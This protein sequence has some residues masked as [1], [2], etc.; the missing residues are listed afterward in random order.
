MTCKS[1]RTPKLWSIAHENGRNTRKRQVVG[2]GSKKGID[3][4]LYHTTTLKLRTI[5][6]KMAITHENDEFLDKAQKTSP[7]VMSL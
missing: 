4:Q 6:H 1:P 7:T 5:A 2:H 3:Y